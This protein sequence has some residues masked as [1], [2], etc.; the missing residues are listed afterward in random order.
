MLQGIGCVDTG[1]L[2]LVLIVLGDAACLVLV[3]QS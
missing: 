1:I 2:Y 3:H